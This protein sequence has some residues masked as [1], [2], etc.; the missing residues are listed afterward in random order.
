MNVPTDSRLWYDDRDIPFLR[1]DLGEE[2]TIRQNDAATV[3]N[4]IE[5]G[6]EPDVAVRFVQ[7]SNLGVLLGGHTGKVSVQLNDPNATPA[8]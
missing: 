8:P 3:R 7:T 2:A 6:Y 1:E 4:L 5:A